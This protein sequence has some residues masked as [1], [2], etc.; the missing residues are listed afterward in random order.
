M[1]TRISL[2]VSLAIALGGCSSSFNAHQ[3]AE[4]R[5][6][7]TSQMSPSDMEARGCIRSLVA[8]EVTRQTDTLPAITVCCVTAVE[9]RF[10]R[11]AGDTLVLER[12]S[13]VAVMSDGSRIRGEHE[14]LTVVRT[15]GTEVTVRQIDRGRTT[16]L[17][18]GI[19]AAVIGLLALGASQ[20]EYGFPPSAGGTFFV[21]PA[22]TWP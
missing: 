9:G 3:I 5:G 21:G 8:L 22:G 10:L 2:C 13:G 14:V 11:T 1:K 19:T 18:L 4:L 16:A 6:A 7:D 20:I 17:L 15:S 12:G